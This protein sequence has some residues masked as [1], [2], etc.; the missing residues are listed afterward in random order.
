MAEG[1]KAYLTKHVTDDNQLMLFKPYKDL[2][3]LLAHFI[4]ELNP[5]YPYPKALSST[6]VEM[7]H[8]QNYYLK[9][10]PSLNDFDPLKSGVQLQLFLEQLIFKSLGDNKI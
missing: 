9:Y 2:C 1:A 10:L 8:S 3:A 5:D 4:T 6:I 7:A